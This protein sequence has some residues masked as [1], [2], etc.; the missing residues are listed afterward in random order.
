LSALIAIFAGFLGVGPGFLLMPTLVT[1]GYTARIA[2]AT[3][4]VIVTLPSFSAFIAHLANAQFNWVMVGITSVTAIV[5]A[6][7]G[8]M[9][10][11]RRVKSRTL[12]RIFALALVILAV[13][14]VLI[15][16]SS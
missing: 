4:S 9:F 2:A 13:Q 16:L 10:M 8:G 6:Y 7:S 12:S 14:R 5:G 15:L 3:N 11:A 1:L